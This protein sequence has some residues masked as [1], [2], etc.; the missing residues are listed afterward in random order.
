MNAD[1]T[2]NQQAT[3]RPHFYQYILKGTGEETWHPSF[4]YYG[5]RYLQVEKVVVENENNINHLPEILLI[6]GL[7]ISNA[8]KRIGAFSSS[9]SL[10]NQTNK[11]IDWSI[12]SNMVSV[13]TDCPHR[14][15][16]GWLEQTY[17]VGSSVK[18]AYDIAALCR[19]T[20]NDIKNAQTDKGL[21]PEIAPEFVKFDEPFRDSPEWGSAG[22]ILPWLMYQWYGDRK[23][24]QENYSMMKNYIS[25]LQ[26]KDSARILVQGLGD[27]FDLG[28]DRPGVSQLTPKGLTATAT[29]YYVTKLMQQIASLLNYTTEAK[30]Y[31]D[32]SAE[33]NH[34]FNQR[35]F[36]ITTKQYGS[37]SQTSNAMALY[38]DLVKEENKK[39]VLNNLIVDIQSRN[40]A[41]TAGDIGY[42]Y[43]LKVLSDAGRGDIIFN[44]NNRSDVPGYG[45]QITKGATALTESWQALPN[46]SNNHFMLG[47]IMEWFYEGLAGIGQDSNSVAY[48]K[49]A[50][51]PQIVG[52]IT[53]AQASFQSPYG[54]ISSSWQ[55]ENNQFVLNVTV[56]TNTTAN[57]YLPV[58]AQSTIIQNG[59]IIHT[60][61]M[62]DTKAVINIG[63]GMYIFQVVN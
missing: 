59:K 45:Y 48:K 63:S 55:K 6:K 7:H 39:A 2:I 20:I 27:W 41:L 32:L 40:N 19:K 29:Y 21:I 62:K 1:G 10:F 36:N 43:L 30:S 56:P 44:M 28:S 16:L 23:M 57:I 25:Y 51:K 53:Q 50:I 26:S 18:Y 17:L 24:L 14:E 31:A 35:F 33:I 5:F 61:K 34:A 9:N 37:G 3:G 52:N 49:I 13:F 58:T 54:T 60:K 22:I 46:V 38:M 11:L 12:K 15:K 4:T 47:H 8:A 42:R